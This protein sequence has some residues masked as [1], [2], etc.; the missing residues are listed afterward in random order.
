[1]TLFN[2]LTDNSLVF[3]GLFAGTI[4]FMEY[5]FATS[6]LGSFYVDK[7]IQTDAWED[8][9]NRASQIAYDSPTSLDTVTPV[10]HVFT[11]NTGN[12]L[13]TMSPIS[14]TLTSDTAQTVSTILPVPLV[15]IEIIP[16]RDIAE[17]GLSHNSLVET[18][19]QEIKGLYANEM[20]DYMI[21]NVDLAY[22]VK[23]Y[24]I[25]QLS[26]S[27]INEAILNIMS[28]FNG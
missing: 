4:G 3:Y 20:Y 24:T 2:F 6:Y 23:S 17:Y 10:S 12:T 21:T 14:P 1:M 9:S 27:G 8:Y 7:G 18:K 15:E 25:T 19:I 11:S 22:I 13:S 26:S 16:N 28:C 5:S